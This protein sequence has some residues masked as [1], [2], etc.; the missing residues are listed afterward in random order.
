MSNKD[1]NNKEDVAVA[2]EEM[3]SIYFNRIKSFC[4]NYLRDEAVAKCT[5][6]E[7]FITVWENRANLSF[8]DEIAPYLFL[9]AKNRC[10]NL[11]KREKI[12]QKF[13]DVSRKHTNESINCA[14]LKDVAINSLYSKEIEQL[15]DVAVKKMPEKVKSTYYLSR[16]NN[17]KYEQIAEIQ[18]I[19][20][21][22]VEYRIMFALRILR[23]ILK[24][25]LP[26]L[27]GYFANSLF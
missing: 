5:T 16:F 4:Y 11:L 20:V 14:A 2:F 12:H 24:D 18:N 26:L 23:K 27:L 25:Y 7:V 8:T 10:L 15:F 3:Y 22:T 17:F 21:K 9:L 6:Q 1:H 13:T 19:S